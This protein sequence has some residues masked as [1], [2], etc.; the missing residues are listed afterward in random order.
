MTTM[1]N[2]KQ[3]P[4]TQA[5][6]F[7]IE[8]VHLFTQLCDKLV[9]YPWTMLLHSGQSQHIN[10]RFDI[11][12]SHPIATIVTNLIPSFDSNAPIGVLIDT[13][14][15]Y[16]SHEPNLLV[17][18]PIQGT[19]D[20]FASCPFACLDKVIDNY[21]MSAN[22]R[23][24]VPFQ[25]GALGLFTY[26]LG[27]TQEYIPN[28]SEKIDPLPAM[29]VGI[30]DV[31]FIRDNILNKLNCVI[32]AENEA[33]AKTRFELYLTQIDEL[34]T[35]NSKSSNVESRFQ[36]TSSWQSTITATDY[37]KQFIQVQEALEAGECYQVNLTQAFQ[38]TYEG[39]EW[40][41][42]ND[43]LKANQAPFSAFCHLPEAKILSASPER[44]LLLKKQQVSTKPIKGTI[45]RSDDI[46]EDER[47]KKILADSAKNRAENVMIVDLLRNDLGK[48]ARPGTVE[49]PKL[50]EIESF[51]AVHHLV[52][53][54]SAQL[55]DEITPL[56][57]LRACFPGGSI[58]G[59]PKVSA[60]QKIEHIEPTQRSIYCG[61]IAYISACG[62]MD[63]NIAIRTLIAIPENPEGFDIQEISPRGKLICFAGGGIVLDSIESEE[64]EEV[65]AKLSKILT[66]WQNK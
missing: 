29:S 54:I 3:Y 43:L 52:S 24:D 50:F 33:E 66:L 18:E 60:M 56:A 28:I 58:T 61:S 37:H 10:S 34:A 39:D 51:P 22:H 17:Y 12:V 20:K 31:A 59:A 16:L 63:S 2:N 35:E 13:K 45:A 36:L 21:K 42:F 65:Y 55:K 5:F 40:Q 49:V 26:D 1:Y 25:G 46:Y 19:Q 14:I 30:Y 4:N 64:Y 41:A 11:L 38:A 15:S 32:Q 27:R 8:S 48:I 23:E 9:Y 53:T 44:F 47:N 62:Q 57:L 6:I 7:E